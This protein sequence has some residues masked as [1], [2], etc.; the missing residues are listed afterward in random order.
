MGEP[1]RG[2]S[3]EGEGAESVGLAGCVV[4][5]FILQELNERLPGC[6]ALQGS[7]ETNVTQAVILGTCH[8]WC[9]TSLSLYLLVVGDVAVGQTRQQLSEVA[10]LVALPALPVGFQVGVEALG[11]VLAA[12]HL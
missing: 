12:L 2:R 5:L 10:P 1:A 8:R 4:T 11:S 3:L 6:L 9:V 7:Q